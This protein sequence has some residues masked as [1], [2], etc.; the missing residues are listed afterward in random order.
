M[1]SSSSAE[2]KGTI[3]SFDVD[4]SCELDFGDVVMPP[5]DDTP[6]ARES[7]S[8]DGKHVPVSVYGTENAG[9]GNVGAGNFVGWGMLLKPG[10]QA[11]VRMLS[12]TPPRE[13]QYRLLPDMESIGW[14]YDLYPDAPWI[15]DFVIQGTVMG[16]GCVSLDEPEVAFLGR[17][18]E[19]L[20]P[21]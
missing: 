7:H 6:F 1:S 13:R 4:V 10:E 20:R 17:A 19:H 15:P 18:E 9:A 8:R 2:N 16:P 11:T 14:R 5:G 21:G 3:N 12:P